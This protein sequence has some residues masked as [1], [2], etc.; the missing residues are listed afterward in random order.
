MAL[1]SR[2]KR[3]LNPSVPYQ[4]DTRLIVIATEGRETE[5]QYFDQFGDKRVHVKMLTTGEDNQSAP[6]HVIERLIS[7]SDEYQI[8]G[9]DELWLMVDVDRWKSLGEIVREAFHRGY[10]LAI[11]NPCFEVWLL[12]HFQDPPKIAQKCQPIE[13][14]LR[15]ALG[16]GYSKSN[17]D[18]SQ[19]ADKLDSA[20]KR[21]EQLDINP[22]DRW[23]QS[24]GSHVYRVVHS[25]RGLVS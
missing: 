10:K 20:I 4:R 13:D 9:D 17:L 6:Q 14:T 19:F 7:Y 18:I 12:C 1:T 24:V 3:P 16:G 2:K 15:E 8:G 25:I 22:K 23:P 5:K 21:T 11:S